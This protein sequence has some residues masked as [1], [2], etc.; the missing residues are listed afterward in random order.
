MQ[1]KHELSWSKR[2]PFPS[3]QLLC[4]LQ[5]PCLLEYVFQTLIWFSSWLHK[6]L[7]VQP[8]C[9]FYCLSFSQDC[10]QLDGCSIFYSHG[11][12]NLEGCSISGHW[13]VVSLLASS[14]PACKQN[15]CFVLII[16]F[17]GKNVPLAE[18]KQSYNESQLNDYGCSTLWCK[19]EKLS[20]A[21]C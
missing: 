13:E 6:L 19:L 15:L 7:L 11:H 20:S 3:T 21:S 8:L 5:E 12:R 1:K 10:L 9:K 17:L 2:E 14:S 4:L 18:K 16:C